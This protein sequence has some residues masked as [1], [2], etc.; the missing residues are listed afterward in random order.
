MKTFSN[1]V[2]LAIL[3]LGFTTCDIINPEEQVPAYLEIA[4]FSL[5]TANGEGSASENITEVWV[6]IDG[7][8]LGV[9]DLPAT[10]PVLKY[11]ATEV[12]LDAGIKDNGIS[13]TPEIYPFYESY[14]VNLDLEANKTEVIEPSIGYSSDTKFSFIEDFEDNRPRIF[15]EVLT[16]DTE[17]E[18]VQSG[19]F[20]GSYS[21][22][23][24]L[25]RDTRPVVEIATLTDFSGLQE[26]GVYVYLEVNF[27][28][29]VPIVWGLSGEPFAGGG[30][31]QYYEPGS[32]ASDEWKKI[33]FNLSS[34]VFDADLESYKIV[35][36]AL[37]TEN[38]PD[39]AEVYLDNIKLVH[40]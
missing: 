14:T 21:G 38:S 1:L 33:Y 22:Y 32:L 25:E 18:Q 36:Q 26:D 15:T 19:V 2:G 12:R 35:F 4:P 8:F 23:F 9:Y 37:L 27:K 13:D 17:L 10:V 16:G 11:G 30:E 39:T 5:S 20:E 40:F 28:S 7:A 3:L 29:D 34:L 24:T 31:V 6:F